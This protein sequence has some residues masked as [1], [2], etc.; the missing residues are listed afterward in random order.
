[1][2]L[3]TYLSRTHFA[4]GVLEVAL[5][6]ELELNKLSK[7]LLLSEQGATDTEFRE[8]VVAG[9]PFWC[10]FQSHEIPKQ[11]DLQQAIERL[12]QRLYE[13]N[14]DVIIAFGSSLA[15]LAADACCRQ[16]GQEKTESNN[17]NFLT[18]PKFFAIPGVDGIPIMSMRRNDA[19]RSHIESSGIQPTAVILDPTLIIG[20]TV[21]RTSS[22]I[23]DTLARCLSAHF[24][25]GYNPPAKGI[26][27]EGVKRIQR[28]LATLVEED[29][30]EMR[31]ELMAASLNGTL[32]TQQ[33]SGIAQELCKIL[34]RN[35]SHYINK[36]ALMRL[37]ILVEAEL[38]ELAW[39][40][41]RI[42]EVSDALG[43]PSGMKLRDWLSSIM[44]NL[45]LPNSL[46]ELG[47]SA[48]HIARAADEVTTGRS[49]VPSTE[50]LNDMLNSVELGTRNR[51]AELENG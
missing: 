17:K 50:Y 13:T 14:A 43:V 27:L 23:A 1:M 41:H 25:D 38:L 18:C 37:L 44:E 28:N 9:L 3:I 12:Q 15:L 35:S 6:S 24:S 30:L 7:P 33:E 5:S 48:A 39:T 22:A 11:N 32:A 4:D 26:A 51:V 10:E 29:S 46:S 42:K 8:R 47:L 19:I 40:T 21:E 31:R 2:T 49:I 36:G 20:E 16:F 45:P 34:L